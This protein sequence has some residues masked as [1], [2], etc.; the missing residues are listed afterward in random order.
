[1]NNLVPLFVNVL[2]ND[3]NERLLAGGKA[4]AGIVGG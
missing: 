2:V 3:V 4:D 1:M